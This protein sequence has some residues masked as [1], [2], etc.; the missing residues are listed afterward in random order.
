M[1][2]FLGIPMPSSCQQALG[3]LVDEVKPGL[4][5][6]LSWTRPENWHLTLRF[7]GDVEEKRVEEVRT[8]L[9]RM[10]FSPFTMQAGRPGFFPNDRKPRVLWLGLDQGAPQCRELFHRV[11]DL[12]EPLGMSKEK[13]PFRAH[14]TLARIRQDK[15]D[16]WKEVLRSLRAR[17]WPPF[18]CRELVFWKS[19][20][21]PGGPRYTRLQTCEAG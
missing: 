11:E 17:Q 9:A 10:T 18:A 12:M 2:C 6:R 21:G 13:R 15:G 4:H 5:S 16:D 8:A 14:L 7:L 3:R 19:D 1:R 20:L